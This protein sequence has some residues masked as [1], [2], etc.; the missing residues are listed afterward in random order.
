[1]YY[2]TSCFC[3]KGRQSFPFK[4]LSK[5]EIPYISINIDENIFLHI[6]NVD[7][8]DLFH[9]INA[10]EQY[11]ISYTTLMLIGITF[12]AQG[13]ENLFLLNILIRKKSFT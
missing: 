8:N 11:L 10:D 12:F 7:G 3:S 5:K 6:I 2:E 13:A 4:Y 9:I 1:M